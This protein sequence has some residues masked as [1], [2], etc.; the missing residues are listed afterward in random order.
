MNICLSLSSD[1]YMFVKSFYTFLLALIHLLLIHL[2]FYYGCIV[3]KVNNSHVFIYN[4]Y[5]NIIQSVWNKSR[6]HY[7][8]EIEGNISWLENQCQHRILCIF[9]YIIS[10]MWNACKTEKKNL[11]NHNSEAYCLFLAFNCLFYDPPNDILA[12]WH[13]QSHTATYGKPNDH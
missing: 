13:L 8:R 5:C 1:E 9:V 4:I 3:F 2:V 10:C 6:N 12:F 7:T 11:Q